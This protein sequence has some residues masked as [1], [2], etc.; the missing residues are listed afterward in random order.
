MLKPGLNYVIEQRACLLR[1]GLK[2]KGNL[3]VEEF[4]A[5]SESP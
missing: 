5:W 2:L 1:E 4:Y 3:K